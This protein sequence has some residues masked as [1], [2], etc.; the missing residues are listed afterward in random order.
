MSVIGRCTV[1]AILNG[2]VARISVSCEVWRRRLAVALVSWCADK[3]RKA[4]VAAL[5]LLAEK[6]CFVSRCVGIGRAVKL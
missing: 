5:K 4:Q 1:N 2:L 6:L 3:L